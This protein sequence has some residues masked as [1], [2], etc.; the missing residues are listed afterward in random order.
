MRSNLCLVLECIGLDRPIAFKRL[1]IAWR[2]VSKSVLS[3][4]LFPVPSVYV[5]VESAS[6]SLPRAHFPC[7]MHSFQLFYCQSQP[8][9][10]MQML[11][12]FIHSSNCPSE[13]TLGYIR[14]YGF[15]MLHRF[16]AFIIEV[17]VIN[18]SIDCL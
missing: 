4:C 16:V 13:S 8:D 17:Y 3:P 2:V 5:T 9:L 12:S 10:A 7:H 6:S 18:N 14:K 11:R 1:V 15:Q